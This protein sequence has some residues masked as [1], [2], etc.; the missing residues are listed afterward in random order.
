MTKTILVDAWNTLVTAAGINT[1]LQAILDT[2]SNPKIIL[3]N[4][5]EAE[6]VKFGIVNVPYPVFSLAHNPDKTNPEYY[7]AMLRHFSITA[8]QVIYVEHNP[9]AVQSAQSVGIT[10]WQY[11]KDAPDLDAVKAFLQAQLGE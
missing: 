10:T 5:T 3:T 4:A 8:D 9:A 7:R 6:K 1:D 11:P 2:F